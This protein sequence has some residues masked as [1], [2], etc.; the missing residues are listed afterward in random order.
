MTMVSATLKLAAVLILGGVSVLAQAAESKVEITSFAYVGGSYN[1]AEICG[2][3][4][5]LS[6]AVTV[7]VLVDVHSRVPGVY[8]VIAGKD[9][10]FCTVV[11]SYQGTAM[12][13]I[14]ATEVRSA[15]VTS[16]APR[17]GN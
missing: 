17:A 6:A 8:N 3:A 13:S 2:M 14:E 1:V 16:G 5:G 4:T 15:E 11:A 7:R 10:H 12:A 9:G